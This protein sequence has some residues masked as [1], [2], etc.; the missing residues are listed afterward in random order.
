MMEQD[1]VPYGRKTQQVLPIP[2]ID[3]LWLSAALGCDG[4]TISITAATQPSLEDIVLGAIPGLPK[5]N[6]HNPVLAYRVGQSFLD[7][8]QRAAAGKLGPFIL[9]VEGS[10]PNEQNK[11]IGRAHV[12]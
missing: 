4:D 9:V 2:E 1:S 3:I 12:L 8:F 7:V 5:V 6:F 10:I 11:Q